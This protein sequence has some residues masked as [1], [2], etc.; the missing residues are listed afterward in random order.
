MARGEGAGA[1]TG[2]AGGRTSVEQVSA[3]A[4][5]ATPELA[6]GVFKKVF[7]QF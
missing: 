1:T 2:V 7:E 6:P 3:I 4:S 5:G